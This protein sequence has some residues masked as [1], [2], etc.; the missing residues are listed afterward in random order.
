MQGLSL[1]LDYIKAHYISSPLEYDEETMP[2]NYTAENRIA[3]NLTH[4]FI[5]FNREIAYKV[6]VD[7]YDETSDENLHTKL[8]EAYAYFANEATTEKLFALA[9]KLPPLSIPVQGV[10]TPPQEYI[11]LFTSVEAKNKN[12]TFFV[13]KTLNDKYE[14]G[15]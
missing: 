2:V 10:K 6:L 4:L 5:Y 9:S 7:F 13:I 8:R 14:F 15:D 12:L 11:N 3:E 1:V